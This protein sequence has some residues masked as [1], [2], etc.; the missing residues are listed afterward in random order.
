VLEASAE[1][2]KQASVMRDE[3]EK[4]IAGVRAA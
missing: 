2:A 4:Y 3:V 1:L